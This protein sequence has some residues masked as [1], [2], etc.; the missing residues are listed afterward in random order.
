MTDYKGNAKLIVCYKTIY[1]NKFTM[2][3]IDVKSL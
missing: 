2:Q 3:V 1:I